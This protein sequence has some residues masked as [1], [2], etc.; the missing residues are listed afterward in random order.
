MNTRRS[1]CGCFA[2]YGE[3]ILTGL[4]TVSLAVTASWGKFFS[5]EGDAAEH[6]A[7]VFRAAGVVAAFLHGDTVLQY[8][9]HQLCLPFQPDDGE[10]PQGNKQPSPVAGEHQLFVKQSPDGGRNLAGSF[11]AAA[12]ADFPDA[13]TENHGIQHFYC[14][15]QFDR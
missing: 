8:G 13:G 9:N 14:E 15:H 4:V 7:G 2:V 1:L 10:L 5:R 6:L 12:F 11:C 3:I